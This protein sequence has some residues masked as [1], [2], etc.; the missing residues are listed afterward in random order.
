MKHNFRINTRFRSPH[1]NGQYKESQSTGKRVNISDLE[2]YEDGDA[3]MKADGVPR[4]NNSHPLQG[5]AAPGDP[6]E[7][8]Q[9]PN[10]IVK[11]AVNKLNVLM[12]RSNI[13]LFEERSSSSPL[14]KQ[15]SK[16]MD[17]FKQA[18]DQSETIIELQDSVVSQKLTGFSSP[19][20]KMCVK[21]A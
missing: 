1:A 9:S 12:S 7:D 4:R 19:T 2:A 5:E 13:N 6:D 3:L 21:K 16:K 17:E 15:K 8:Q 10:E 18:M 20:K 11:N 14:K